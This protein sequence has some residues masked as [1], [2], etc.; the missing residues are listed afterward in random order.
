MAA[1]ETK[2]ANFAQYLK[3]ERLEKRIRGLFIRTRVHFNMRRLHHNQ[4]FRFFLLTMT[5]QQ[6]V[7][8]YRLR[9]AK[10]LRKAAIIE[11]FKGVIRQKF[12]VGFTACSFSV[13][14]LQKFREWLCL[15]R[16][17]RRKCLKYIW[18]VQLLT[19]M[20]VNQDSESSAIVYLPRNI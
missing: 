16:N 10:Q 7:K 5:F 11:L 4:I 19:I 17:E 12:K 13:R 8:R 18:K 20:R 14:K 3:L 6:Y 9:K 2:I 1:R 15:V